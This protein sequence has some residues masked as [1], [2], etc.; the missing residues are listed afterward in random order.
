MKRSCL[1]RT[2]LLAGSLWLQLSMLCLRSQAAVSNDRFANAQIISGST[3]T[4]TGSNSG[5]NKEP[6][7]P[8]HAD[9][10]GGSSIWFRWTAPASGRFTFN[11]FGSSFDTLL[12]VYT[13]SS[14]NALTVLGSN[15]D[16][17]FESTSEVRVLATGGGTYYVAVDGYTNATG[18]VILNWLPEPPP[19][20]N[21]DFANA[22][23]ISG[24]TNSTT[25]SNFGATLEPGEP[26]H[27]AQPGGRSVWFRWTAPVTGQASFNT[28][29]SAIDTLLAAYSG[30]SVSALTEIAANDDAGGFPSAVSFPATNG[31]SYALAVDGYNAHAGALVLNWTVAIPEVMPEAPVL[32]FTTLH[33][34]TNGSDGAG[35]QAGLVL[36]GDTLYGTTVS[37]GSSGNGTVFKASV[38]GTSYTVLHHFNYTAGAN[39]YAALLLSGSTLYGTTRLGGSSGWG[40]VF[41]MGTNGAGFTLLHQ[42]SAATGTPA[43]N[44]GGALPHAKLILS[45][46]GTTL[47]GAA[48][49]GGKWGNGTLFAVNTDGTGFTNLYSFAATAGSP[50]TNGDGAMP[51]GGLILSGNTLYGAAVNGGNSGYGTV[52]ALTTNGLNFTT[53]HHFGWNSDGAYPRTMIL[54]GNTLYGTCNSGGTSGNG[55]VYAVNT[56]GTGFTNLYQFFGSSGPLN[57]NTHGANPFA[58][59][60]LS[61]NTLYGT[62]LGGGNSGKGTVFAVNTD[63]SALRSLY[64]FTAASGSAFTNSDGASPRAELVLSGN[65]VYGT[66]DRGG[67]LGY[68]TVFRLSLVPR[69]RLMITASQP[70]VVLTWATNA[71]P[72]ALQATTNLALPNFWSVVG[73]ASVTN[74]GQISVTVPASGGRQIFRL[75]AP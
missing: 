54:S 45:A 28:A 8:D 46:S 43:T 7:E 66:T 69:P 31:T 35:P 67:G 19:P 49:S 23:V 63:G 41:A 74:S 1:V 39:P 57:T 59:L 2:I 34:F 55:T 52:F 40:T 30:A 71:E 50:G 44:S 64:H 65:T 42:F 29:G 25:G 12:A 5:A 62:S 72:F 9:E 3:G 13:G 60:V 53:L 26:N 51:Y 27:A 4:T 56:S 75:K 16:Y 33:S 47:Y 20:L 15:D 24:F 37:G 70:T 11:T 21:D 38:D 10:P 22:Q 58:G 36:S 18:T 17:G 14:V 61:G 32:T 6:G 73:Q 48:T 68:G